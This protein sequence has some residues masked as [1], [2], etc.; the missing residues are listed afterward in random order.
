LFW[1]AEEKNCGKFAKNYSVA[2]LAPGY[3]AFL[4]PGP[5]SGIPNTYFWEVMVKSS[6]IILK[7][8]KVFSSAFQNKIILNYVKSVATKNNQFFFITLFCCCF[9]IRDPRSG[10][11]DGLKVCI[12]EKYPRSATLKNCITFYQNKCQKAI[13]N[14]GFWSEIRDPEKP[15]P[16]FGS[17]GQKTT[18]SQIPKSQ[19]WINCKLQIWD[20]YPAKKSKF[21]PIPDPES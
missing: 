7:W 6:K 15:I 12:R 9:W 13:N 3:G 10:I 8:P 17:R 1:N 18:R 21:F 19:Y 2:D 5:W 4:T 16:D 20:N 11:H 14:R